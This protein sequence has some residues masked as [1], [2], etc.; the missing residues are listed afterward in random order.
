LNEPTPSEKIGADRPLVSVLARGAGGAFAVKVSGAGVSLLV[1]VLL[2]RL[3][4]AKSFGDYVYVV[5]WINFLVLLSKA[6]IDVAGQ[7]FIA[8]YN[9]RQQWS[10]LRGFL[11]FSRIYTW[12]LAALVSLVMVGVAALLRGRI[13]DGLFTAFCVGALLLPLVTRLQMVESCLRALKQ[14]IQA[15]APQELLRPV[16]IIAGVVIGYAV[17]ERRLRPPEALGINAAATLLVLLLSVY[18]FRRALPGPVFKVQSQALGRK[19]LGVG[20]SLAASEG[21]Y[22]VIAQADIIMVG[23]FM[24]TEKAGIYAV[25]SRLAALVSFGI[26]AVNTI[27]APLVS[28]ITSRGRQD[29]LKELLSW[30][31]AWIALISIPIIVLLAVFGKMILGWFGPE[32]G[33]GY[34]V[35]LILSFGQ[36][37]NAL[38]GSVGTLMNMTG[39]HGAVARIVGVTAGLNIVLNAIAIP[40][41]GMW[42]AAA[43]SVITTIAWNAAMLSFVVRKKGIN[44][45]LFHRRKVR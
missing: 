25:A 41:L 27:V 11:S 5:T 8:A 40:L 23:F 17:I 15:Q 16:L 44:P 22:L 29:K 42:G 32:F 13:G 34:P 35:L 9:E 2:A 3:L 36:L 19:W 4:G 33:E 43:A 18:L 20:V 24:G 30:A 31:A 7:R 37:I 12:A 14:I 38:C 28:E 1:Q 6:G 10:E 21:F 45:T 39:H 26:I